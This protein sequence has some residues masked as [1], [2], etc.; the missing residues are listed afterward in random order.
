VREVLHDAPTK[1]VV[2]GGGSWEKCRRTI[3]FG[4]GLKHNS[5]AEGDNGAP[6]SDIRQKNKKKSTEIGGEYGRTE[7]GH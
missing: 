7:R 6:C 5:V 2:Q 3:L 1:G 4:H